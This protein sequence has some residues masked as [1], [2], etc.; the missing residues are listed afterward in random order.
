LFNCDIETDK[1][2]EVFCGNGSI[3]AM[4]K[5]V[6]KLVNHN[7]YDVIHIHS[8]LTGVIF[9]FAIFPFKLSLLKKTLF[10]LHN[11]W[12]VLTTRNK[13]LDL[14]IMTMSKKVCACS[15]SSLNSIP[16]P[17]SYFLGKKLKAVVNGFNN[18]RMDRVKTDKKGVNHFNI[19][20]KIKIIYVGALNNTKNQIALLEALKEIN[21]EGELI[22]LGDGVNRKKLCSYSKEIEGPLK[23]DF[24]GRVSRDIAIEHML[25]ADVY[26]SLSKGE[27][28]PIA[29]LEAMY[30]GCFMILS[31]IPPHIEISPPSERCFFV[32]I[33][34]KDETIKS[35][36][37]VKDN[38]Q[39]IKTGREISKEHSIRGFSV[40]NM[41]DGYQKIY[42]SIYVENS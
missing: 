3:L 5:I 24:K 21:I 12:N 2:I 25:E 32:D 18:H 36:N 28:L 29:A 26:V 41:L 19:Y 42:N 10:T 14:V 8:G 22:F 27:G 34:N 6:R 31:T 9:F 7:N 33:L 20:S 4:T 40:N 39:H 15:N 1:D 30:S 17:I 35:L 23:I 11:S 38:I 13:I 37:Y 16:R